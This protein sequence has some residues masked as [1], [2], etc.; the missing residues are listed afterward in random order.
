MDVRA[1]DA[2]YLC[3]DATKAPPALVAHLN[4][5]GVVVRPY[6]DI[7][8]LVRAA[9]GRVWLDVTNANYALFQVCV[10]GGGAWIIPVPARTRVL[11]LP[12]G[13]H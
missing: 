1:E 5:A 9:P 8:G 4:E 13:R 11:L 2:A 7:L 12:A 6:E 10:W 3:V